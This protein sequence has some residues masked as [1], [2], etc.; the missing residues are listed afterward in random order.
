MMKYFF[1]FLFITLNIGNAY[2][3]NLSGIGYGK[4]EEEA[5]KEA[6][7]DLSSIIKVR[8]FSKRQQS[9]YASNGDLKSFQSSSFIKL[10]SD[11]SLI[12]PKIE[13]FKEKDTIKA[14]ATI[15]NPEKYIA[16]LK[17]LTAKINAHT[18]FTDNELDEVVYRNIEKA[19]PIYH[20]YENYEI[21]LILYGLNDYPKP[22]LSSAEARK[23]LIDMGQTPPNLEIAAE[24]LTKP[25]MM[26]SKIYVSHPQYA[27]ST[28]V[29]PFSIMFKEIL[30]GKIKGLKNKDAASYNMAC[31]YITSNNDIIMSCSL[32]SGGSM[33]VASSIV[34]IPYHLI[35]G[36][37]IRGSNTNMASLVNNY[38]NS[39][40]SLKANLKISSGNDTAILN[41]GENITLLV[42]ANKKSYLYFAVHGYNI[43]KSASNILSFSKG[44]TFIKEISE[45]DTNKWISLGVWQVPDMVGAY[46]IQIFATE[47]KPSIDILPKYAQNNY[48]VL[49][50]SSE[51]VA[52]DL[53]KTFSAHKGDKYMTSVNYTVIG[54]R[55]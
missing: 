3:E 55:Q 36:M 12:N 40:S 43:E 50:K 2:G 25:M 28:E 13:Y 27:G 20:E 39:K 54:S 23:I 17:E 32:I 16:K 18:T 44:K 45:N 6:L 24:I 52:K 19:M 22:R 37:Q 15:D 11:V 8:V 4:T 14:V 41:T 7:S 35:K 29:T 49:P 47:N 10:V 21:I 1:I 31:S 33:T 51:E 38:D 48:K 42:K 26:K 9:S 5:K 53:L 34:K 46:T 30:D